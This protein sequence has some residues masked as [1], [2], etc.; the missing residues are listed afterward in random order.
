MATLASPLYPIS[1]PFEVDQ[2]IV[3]ASEDFLFEMNLADNNILSAKLTPDF[4]GRCNIRGL[5]ALILDYLPDTNGE[6]FQV[7]QLVIKL[8]G[9][10]VAQ[11]KILPCRSLLT[12]PAHLF[13]KHSFLTN[14]GFRKKT[15]MDAREYLFAFYETRDTKG[16]YGHIRSIW[17]DNDNRLQI[18]EQALEMDVT[19]LHDNGSFYQL[20]VSPSL[21]TPPQTVNNPRLLKYEVY[22]DG[23]KQEYILFTPEVNIPSIKDFTFINS[24]NLLDTFHCYGQ[25]LKENKIDYHSAMIQSEFRNYQIDSVPSWKVS[26]GPI[27]E[28]ETTLLDDFCTSKK[29]KSNEGIPLT[30]TDSNLKCSDDWAYQYEGVITYRESSIRPRTDIECQPQTFDHSFD[31]SFE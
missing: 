5:A 4:S 9:S 25:S 20:D 17:I 8:D 30:I 16:D 12:E 1:F 6:L 3:S 14:C 19:V 7:P 26:T 27:L 29:I 13:T 15:H 31:K 11:T 2:L 23:R 22:S 28:E 24:F 18:V 21:I 10:M